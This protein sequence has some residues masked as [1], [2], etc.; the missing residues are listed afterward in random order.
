MYHFQYSISSSVFVIIASLRT[1]DGSRGSKYSTYPSSLYLQALQQIIRLPYD[2]RLTILQLHFLHFF[3]N[4]NP[5]F[6]V[7]FDF[8]DNRHDFHLHPTHAATFILFSSSYLPPAMHN[9]V[10]T[11]TT[12]FSFAKFYTSI[13]ILLI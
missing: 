7:P 13:F 10:N 9:L 5:D 6:Y 11:T 3:A 8:A 1:H 2:Q 4:A 12:T